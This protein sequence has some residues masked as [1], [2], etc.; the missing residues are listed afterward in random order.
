MNPIAV[1]HDSFL[2]SKHQTLRLIS[3]TLSCLKPCVSRLQ[4]CVSTS[5]LCASH[6]ERCVSHLRPCVPCLKPYVLHL[7]A[8]LSRLKPCVS[9]LEV[10]HGCTENCPHSMQC[11]N[12]ICLN[13]G[14]YLSN[15]RASIPVHQVGQKPHSPLIIQCNPQLS[16]DHPAC[17]GILSL[18]SSSSKSLTFS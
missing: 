13:Y 7:K 5:K 8:C 1:N 2:Q 14:G 9:R 15:C 4:P 10:S 6:L 11:G 12:G 3:Q 16:S 17:C 18:P